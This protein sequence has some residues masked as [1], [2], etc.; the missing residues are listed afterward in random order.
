MF[1]LG[2]PKVKLSCYFCFAL[3]II[4]YDALYQ[5]NNKAVP[6][7]LIDFGMIM[8]HNAVK[9]YESNCGPYFYLSKLE[10]A[11]EAQLWNDIFKWTQRELGVP[12]GTIKACVLVENILSVF[13]LEEILY[14][15][16]EHSMGLNC[17]IWDYCASIIAKLGKYWL[18]LVAIGR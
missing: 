5:I 10:S 7:A 18:V 15:L 13:E 8:Y 4:T 3:R 16:R 2:R 1:L 14:A 17:G 9:L 11:S 6:G 12:Q